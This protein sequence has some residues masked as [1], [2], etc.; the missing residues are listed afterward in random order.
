MYTFLNPQ[1]YV[2]SLLKFIMLYLFI[3]VSKMFKITQFKVFSI[4]TYFT[5]IMFS[6]YALLKDEKY[7]AFV[8]EF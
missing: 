7:V 1:N 3:Q 2:F 8:R 5:I 4:N 6:F